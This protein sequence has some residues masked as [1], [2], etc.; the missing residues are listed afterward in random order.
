MAAPKK[1]VT[2]DEDEVESPLYADEEID[3]EALA[4]EV[5]A[6]LREYLLMERERG[7]DLRIWGGM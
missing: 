6:L 3:R 1:T 2:T 7:G 4:E 5:Y